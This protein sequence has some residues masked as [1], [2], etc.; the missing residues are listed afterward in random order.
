MNMI[1]WLDT[2]AIDFRHALRVCG[3]NP[4]FTA[5]GVLTLILGIGASTALFSVVETVLLRSLPYGR[6]DRLVSLAASDSTTLNAENVSYG[7]VQD[8]KQRSHSFNSVA[9]FRGWGPTHTGKGQPTVLRGMR[10]SHDLFATLGVSPELGRTFSGDEDRPDRWHVVMLSHGYW[11]EAFG[12]RP[13]VLGETILLDQT[14]FQIVGVL[15]ETFAPVFNR[16]SRL[17]Q[18]YAPL[19]YDAS[20]PYACRSCQ[21]VMSVARL[22]EG[23]SVEQARAELNGIAHNLAHDFPKD[24]PPDYSAVVLPLQDR[25]VGKVRAAL[26][27]LLGATG[28]VLLIACVNV[29]NLLLSRYSA[30]RREMAVRA[31]LGASRFRL[32]RQQLTESTLLTLVGGAGGILLAQWALPAIVKWGPPGIPRL[33]DVRLDA[34]VLAFALAVSIVT[35]FLSG[36]APAMH[37]ARSDQRETLQTGG[38]G[39]VGA[40][41]K[42]LRSWLVVA[43]ISIAFVLAVG[44]GLLSKSFYRV[45]GESPGFD[46][47]NVYTADFGL[48]GPKYEKDADVVQFE[49]EVLESVAQMPGVEHAAIVSTLPLGAGY[50]R[51]GFHIKDRPLHS[52]SEAPSVDSYFVS[53]DYFPTMKIPL[54]RG[55]VFA[56][57]DASP[58]AQPVAVIS[59]STAQ[60]LFDGEDALGKAIQLGGRD[61]KK[62][63]ATI[64]GIVG[65]VRQYGLDSAATADAYLLYTHE[66]FSYPTLVVRS[67]LGSA[68]LTR[69]VEERITRLDK[70]VP[71]TGPA[72]MEELV[73]RSVSQRRFVVSL[74]AG[75]CFLSLTLSGF[76]IFGVMAFSVAQRTNEIGVRMALGAKRSDVMRLVL[77]EGTRLAALGILIGLA[78][79]LALGRFMSG[80]LYGTSDKDPGTLLGVAVLLCGVALLACYI[81]VKRATRV[82]PLAA[83]RYE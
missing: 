38:R 61:E 10:V 53:P 39:S 12:S 36:L 43:E 77:G 72:M 29:A 21:H 26:W 79:S 11:K 54:R 82:D 40:T 58:T 13:G 17:P 16:Y 32:A 23:V 3:R 37:A 20:L 18:V 66:T 48:I 27:L 2:A 75:F 14:P 59:E 62:P 60:Q 4:G 81:P 6:P 67:R 64:V 83:L 33:A 15:P 1:N 80:L 57:S 51:R 65:D 5:V 9:M 28:L 24:Y 42:G 31:A 35:G 34:G 30:R 68:A 44:T 71:V 56:E 45:L 41:R 19:G 52:D 47:Q 22:R 25:V 50:D 49:R 70:D 69:G 63:W 74:V 76:G 73:T 46:T 7:L 8:W 78:V 55:R